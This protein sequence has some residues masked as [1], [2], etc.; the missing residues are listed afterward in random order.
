MELTD[1][2]SDKA[3]QDYQLVLKA[4]NAQ[5]QRAYA[6]LMGKYRDSVYFMLMK[7]V[8]N[9]DDAEDLTIETFGKA[10]RRLEQYTPQFAF[11][12]W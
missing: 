9:E 8:N 12:T 10:F 4:L 7:M 1:H 11:S 6:E 3:K 2:L 5:D